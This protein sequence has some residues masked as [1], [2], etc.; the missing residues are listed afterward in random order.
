MIWILI[1][2]AWWCSGMAACIGMSR[3]ER[4]DV[5]ISHLFLMALV[6]FFGPIIPAVGFLGAIFPKIDTDRVVIRWKS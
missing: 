5:T 6:S 2:L 1:A 3:Y 4:E